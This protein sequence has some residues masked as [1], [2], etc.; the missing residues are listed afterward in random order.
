[1]SD[2]SMRRHGA[3]ASASKRSTGALKKAEASRGEMCGRW[4]GRDAQC[5][6]CTIVLYHSRET[7]L[8]FWRLVREHH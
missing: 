8:D 2:E 1:M 4:D 6:S 5:A 3:P 7:F